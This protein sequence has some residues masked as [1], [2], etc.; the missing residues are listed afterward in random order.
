FVA[1]VALAALRDTPDTRITSGAAITLRRLGG[2]LKQAW[3]HPGTRLGLWT[4]FTTQFTGTVFA[5]M[6]GFPFLIAGEGVTRQAASALLTV[7][8][9]TGMAAGPL[10]GV[11]VQRHPLRRSWLVLGVVTAHPARWGLGPLWPGP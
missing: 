2:D 9:L 6:W 5:L 11:L 8:V 4:H 10:I 3:L 1:I 7:Y